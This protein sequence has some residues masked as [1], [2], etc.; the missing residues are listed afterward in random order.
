MGNRFKDLVEYHKLI[1]GHGILAV[2]TFLFIVPAAIFIVRFWHRDPR[3][4]VQVHIWLQIMTVFLSTVVLCLGYFAVGPQRSLTNPHHGIGIAIYV[5]IMFQA[6]WGWWVRRREKGRVIW[7][8][9]MKLMVLDN[10]RIFL[11]Y[12]FLLT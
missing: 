6:I 4:A 10:I 8:I 9:S 5:L 3:F 7:R 1:L 12:L 2:I 11:Q